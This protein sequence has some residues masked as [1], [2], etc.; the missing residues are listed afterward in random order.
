M[1]NDTRVGSED[2]GQRGWSAS[3]IVIVT[4]PQIRSSDWPRRQT[5]DPG[6]THRRPLWNRISRATSRDTIFTPQHVSHFDQIEFITFVPVRD[7]PEPDH[8]HTLQRF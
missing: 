6:Q 2:D 4:P 7:A 8:S 1:G 3:S 5:D